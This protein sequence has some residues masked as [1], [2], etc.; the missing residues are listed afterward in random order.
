MSNG[1][2]APSLRLSNIAIASPLAPA[3]H[4]ATNSLDDINTHIA[5]LETNKLYATGAS[6]FT[7]YQA[8]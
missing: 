6:G 8:G 2:L 1:I 3:L 5:S 4:S 7:M